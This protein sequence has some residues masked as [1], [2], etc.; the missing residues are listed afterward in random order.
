MSGQV[1]NQLFTSDVEASVKGNRWLKFI[2]L[3]SFPSTSSCFGSVLIGRKQ[4]ITVRPKGPNILCDQIT[5]SHLQAYQRYL[6]PTFNIAQQHILSPF[7][8]LFAFIRCRTCGV[9]MWD[10]QQ[11]VQVRRVEESC[12]VFKCYN[13]AFLFNFTASWICSF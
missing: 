6:T 11:R 9:G 5:R 3:T 1:S 7:G 10:I 4:A 12:N 13:V 2:Y 8:S